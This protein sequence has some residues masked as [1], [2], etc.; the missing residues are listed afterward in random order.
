MLNFVFQN[1]TKLI[2]GKKTEYQIGAEAKKYA[3][4][5]LLVTY[6]KGTPVDTTGLYGKV[7]D[8]L[9]QNGVEVFELRKVVANAKLSPVY[10]GIKICRENDIKFL[11]AIGGGS[12]IDTAKSIAV[13]VFYQGDVWDF[14]L[15]KTEVKEALP[16]GVILT[17]PAAGSETSNAAVITKEE[18]RFKK[19][20]KSELIRPQFAIL[21]PELL[22]SL[23]PYQ[24]ACG[25]TDIMAHDMERYFC[26][27]KHVDLSDRLCEAVFKSVMNN[28]PLVLKDP[29]NYDAWA[30]VMWGGT[31]AHNDILSNGRVQ[32]L[33][34][35]DIEHELSGMYNVAHGAGLAVVF[36]AYMKYVYKHDIARFTR[37][38][39]NMMGV[40]YNFNDPE[41]TILEGIYRLERFYERLG[42]PTRLSGLGIIDDRFEEMAMKAT[43]NDTITLGQFKPLNAQDIVNV[44]RLAV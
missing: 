44:L 33:A 35:H 17:I 42:M 37:F 34:S 40:D 12:A 9:K 22:F 39:V 10:E 7:V 15:G 43:Y 1:A 25:C 27:E 24:I 26:N 18:G 2:F 5:V 21:N 3:D 6:E 36:P 30:E 4:K 16:I 14:F 41:E 38:A 8:S 13:G 11:V 19:A 29:H 32:D 23:P 20:F 31:M 28:A